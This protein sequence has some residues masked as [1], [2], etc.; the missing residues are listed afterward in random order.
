MVVLVMFVP[1]SSAVE[2]NNPFELDGNATTNHGTPGPPDDWDR[3]FANSGGSWFS[4]V[5]IAASAEAP[6]NDQ[7]YYT[8]GGSKDDHDIPDWQYTATANPSAPDKDE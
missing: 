1:G 8:G 2:L 3:V 5:F 7:T 6:A 4:R